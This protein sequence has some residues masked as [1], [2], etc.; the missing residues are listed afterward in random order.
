[1][2]VPGTLPSSGRSTAFTHRA[3]ALMTSLV[4]ALGTLIVGAS[5]VHAVGPGVPVLVG[6]L[7]S[8]LGCAEDWAPDCDATA[9]SP[10]GTEGVWAAEVEVP[11]GSGS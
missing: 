1:M 9:L 3:A 2:S 10:T 6:S 7:Q 5:A 8:E 11:K 4:M